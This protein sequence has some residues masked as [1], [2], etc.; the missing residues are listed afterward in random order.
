M[1]QSILTVPIRKV[2]GDSS[3]PLQDLLAIEEP[4][5]IRIGDKTVSITMRTPGHDR[6][7][8]A[9]FLFTEGILQSSDQ[10]AGIACATNSVT[11]HL[12][13][14]IEVDFERLQRHFYTSSALSTI[15]GSDEG[16]AKET[17]PSI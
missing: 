6:E 3:A 17:D 12:K 11:V 10:I 1:N 4:L 13:A 16:K 15:K 8:A 7:L 5:E 9:G 2:E 14:D